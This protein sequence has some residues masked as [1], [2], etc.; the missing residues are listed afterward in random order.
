[1]YFN[2]LNILVTGAK[3]I[4]LLLLLKVHLAGSEYWFNLTFQCLKVS[5]RLSVSVSLSHLVV[6]FQVLDETFHRLQPDLLIRFGQVPEKVEEN[7][8]LLQDP[9]RPDRLG[10]F[11]WELHHLYRHLLTA[12][13]LLSMLLQEE[14]VPVCTDTVSGSTRIGTWRIT[15]TSWYEVWIGTVKNKIGTLLLLLFEV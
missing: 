13:Q 8:V 10:C 4:P 14:N 3:Q 15:A 11:H 1:M 6:G 9:G 7:T 12:T 5:V 2:T